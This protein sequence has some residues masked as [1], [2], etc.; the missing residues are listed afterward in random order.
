LKEL[1]LLVLILAESALETIP[2]E[3]WEHPA[4]KRYSRKYRK[5]PRFLLLDRSY[6]HAAMKTLPESEKRGRPDIVHFALLEALGSPLNKERLLQVYVHTFNN[7][8]IKVKPETRLPRNYNRF[9][10]LMEQLFELGRAP[11]NGQAL[12]KLERKTLSQLLREINPTYVVGFSTAGVPHTVEGVMLRLLNEEKPAVIIGG[13]PHGHFSVATL[14]L[15]NELV[16]ID[17]ETLEAWT[18]TSRVIYEYEC[19]VSL[20]I[21]RLKRQL[22]S[23]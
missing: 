13:F 15:A 8:V 7:Y 12:L 19:A 4:V 18:V 16:R 10:G 14:R 11:P 1:N 22:N 21:K 3:L 6:H 5:T 20:P 9:V 17:L 23:S 2:K